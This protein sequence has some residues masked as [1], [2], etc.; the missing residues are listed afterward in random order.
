MRFHTFLRDDVTHCAALAH[1]EHLSQV[2]S[3]LSWTVGRRGRH[4]PPLPGRRLKEIRS[5]EETM[6]S[7]MWKCPCETSYINLPSVLL[8]LTCKLICSWQTTVDWSASILICPLI[9]SHL[10]IPDELQLL[11]FN[12]TWGKYLKLWLHLFAWFCKGRQVDTEYLV[13]TV[14]LIKRFL[15]LIGWLFSRP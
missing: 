4:V 14:I 5:N 15:I 3:A 12:S 10:P 13:F 2:L 7:P 1:L 8:W 6:N 9:S 11:G